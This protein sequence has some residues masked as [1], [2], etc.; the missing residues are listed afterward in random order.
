LQSG[1]ADDEEASKMSIPLRSI[2][3]VPG[4]SERKIEKS[5][6][7]NADALVYDLEDSVAQVRKPIARQMVADYLKGRSAK[8]GVAQWVRINPLISPECLHDLAAIVAAK[9]SGILLPKV[10][11]PGDIQR[12]SHYLDALEAREG[13]PAGSVKIISVATEIARAPFT[14]GAYADAGLTRLFGITWGA[15]DLSAD[16]GAATNADEDGQLALTYR[17]VRSFALLSAKACRV[18]AIETVYPDFRNLEGLRKSSVAARR[19]GFTGRFAIH[20]DQI[21]VLNE[22]FSPSA[23][24]IAFAERVVAA[25]GAQPEVGAVG[26]DGK[27]LDKPHLVQAQKV[28]TMR[29]A[30]ARR[31]PN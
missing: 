25:F 7:S 22:A 12:V 28:L 21:D 26:V 31:Q 19:E 30:F 20:P 16:L 9:P 2:L 11:G 15:E 23:D 8:L 5:R 17:I 13:V 4:D 29:D 27:M 14:L 3:F 6:G 24:D 10:D 18:E 1:R